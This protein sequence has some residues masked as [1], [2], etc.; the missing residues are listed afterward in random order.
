[1]EPQ[2]DSVHI[3]QKIC[4]YCLVLHKKQKS[5]NQKIYIKIKPEFKRYR[6][7]IDFCKTNKI[8]TIINTVALTNVEKCETN[9]KQANEINCM[10]PL[11]LCRV[12]KKLDIQIVHIS[13][14]MLLME[15]NKYVVKF[16]DTVKWI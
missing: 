10:I 3:G 14:D 1:M 9:Y 8:S 4:N 16:D 2:E 6:R 5:L 7:L 13:N 15:K 12:A 11:R